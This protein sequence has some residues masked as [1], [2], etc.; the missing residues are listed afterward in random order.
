[1]NR[2]P[3]Q[4]KAY[5]V[6]K[7]LW[8]MGKDDH[9]DTRHVKRLN[10]PS[11]KLG[12]CKNAARC[13]NYMVNLGNGYCITCWDKGLGGNCGIPDKQGNIKPRERRGKEHD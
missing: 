5:H 13:G 6:L 9:K 3:K 1:M 8:S 12:S 4:K 11:E 2:P 10:M 7:D